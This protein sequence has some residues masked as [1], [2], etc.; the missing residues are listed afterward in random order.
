[1]SC[2]FVA[3]IK[4]N[5]EEE[6]KKY[7]QDTDEVFSKFEGKYLAVDTH[8]QVLEGTWTHDRAILIEFSDKTKF[9]QWYTSPEYQTILKYRLNAAQ[10]DTLLVE[11]LAN[12]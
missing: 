8:P 11:G 4:F 6:Y 7:L 1:M 2:Y 10:C 5:D 9:E 3:Q 12:T